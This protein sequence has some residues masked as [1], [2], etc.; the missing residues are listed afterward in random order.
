MFSVA[1]IDTDLK[2]NKQK[3]CKQNFCKN[4]LIN[5]NIMTVYFKLIGIGDVVQMISYEVFLT[6]ISYVGTL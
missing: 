1:F 2:I 6:Y 4:L 3:L 5:A